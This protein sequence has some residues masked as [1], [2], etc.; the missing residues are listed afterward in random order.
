MKDESTKPT[1]NNLKIFLKAVT[2]LLIFFLQP[3]PNISTLYA[4]GT[5]WL[6]PKSKA[7]SCDAPLALMEFICQ[8]NKL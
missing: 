8:K 4:V 5:N 3:P 2:H 6:F 1:Q 7:I